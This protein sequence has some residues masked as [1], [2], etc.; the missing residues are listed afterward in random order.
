MTRQQVLTALS[1]TEAEYVDECEAS[2]EAIEVRNIL[3]DILPQE[4]L[5]LRIGIGSQAAYV[6]AT[7][8]TY[9]RR[10]RHIELS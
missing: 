8:P 9:G 2:M 5:S 4:K 6:M 7:Y 1:T 10:T 3:Q